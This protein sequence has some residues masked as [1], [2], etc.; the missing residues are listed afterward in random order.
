[1]GP[2]FDPLDDLEDDLLPP[3]AGG[4]P[5]VVL[6]GGLPLVVLVVLTGELSESGGG[7]L[8]ELLLGL[9]LLGGGGGGPDCPHGERGVSM[10][11]TCPLL[12]GAFALG[13]GGDEEEESGSGSPDC[14]PRDLEPREAARSRLSALRAR[15]LSA[16]P[17]F[18]ELLDNKSKRANRMFMMI[19]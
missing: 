14:K 7:E 1:M 16:L 9:P 6:A 4:L 3:E 5:L 8:G 11:G 15:S 10:P 19:S 13:G 2:P 18:K 17:N 12:V